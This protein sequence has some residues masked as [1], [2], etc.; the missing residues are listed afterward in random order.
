MYHI[1]FPMVSITYLY[2][3]LGQACNICEGNM[4]TC[5]F[6]SLSAQYNW[7]KQTQYCN[8]K[9]M[10]ARTK[11]NF[12]IKMPVLHAIATIVLNRKF[13]EPKTDNVLNIEFA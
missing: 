8:I 7:R 5:F 13:E 4:Q 12:M 9:K 11:V 3:H 1:E 2:R 6:F 10:W